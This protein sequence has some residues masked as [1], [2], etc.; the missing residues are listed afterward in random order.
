MKLCWDNISNMYLMKGGLLR[1]RVTGA[2][3]VIKES[4]KYC[5]EPFLSQPQSTGDFCTH[6]CKGKMIKKLNEK[7]KSSKLRKKLLDL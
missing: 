6:E 5:G 2:K 4:C 1:D 3:Y 7:K